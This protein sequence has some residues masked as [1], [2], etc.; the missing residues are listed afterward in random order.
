VSES[1][2]DPCLG[3]RFESALVLAARLH[4][5]QVRKGTRIP[6]VAHLLAVASLALEHGAYEDEAI[7]AL[8]HDAVEDQGGDP[9]FERIRNEF[10]ERVASLVL[11]LSDARPARGEEK[12]PWRVR[13]ERYLEH[14]DRASPSV[15]M[16]AAADKLHNLRAIVEDLRV[17]GDCV[18]ERVEK[19]DRLVLPRDRADPR[20]RAENPPL[21]PS[22]GSFPRARSRSREARLVGW[23]AEARHF[24][25]LMR[26]TRDGQP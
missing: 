4:R 22:R 16:L 5:D 3:P 17:D 1:E 24:E 14:L 2:T 8:L 19:R 26:G 6:Y 12:P 25:D 21:D 20:E 15:R 13:K 23:R 11:E 7:A 10:G 9:T 18:W